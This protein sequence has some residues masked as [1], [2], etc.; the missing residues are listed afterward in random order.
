MF[1]FILLTDDQD[2]I[3]RIEQKMRVHLALQIF[4]LRPHPFQLQI[5]LLDLQLIDIIDQ[6]ADFAGHQIEAADQTADLI[7]PFIH[8]N[9]LELFV[10]DKLHMFVEQPY[11]QIVGAN[12]N[13]HKQGGNDDR[14]QDQNQRVPECAV[15]LMVDL[16]PFRSSDQPPARSVSCTAERP[17]NLLGR[18]AK[19]IVHIQQGTRIQRGEGTVRGQHDPV[20]L[21]QQLEIQIVT[22]LLEQLLHIVQPQ[23][24]PQIFRV[25][26]AREVIQFAD[27]ADQHLLLRRIQRV[28]SLIRSQQHFVCAA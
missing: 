25:G 11:P 20:L 8:I 18:L 1:I 24:D 21:I 2:R 17:D 27:Q 19:Q 10:F 26:L 14:Q 22:L 3:Q 6:I 5:L 12:N 4:Q 23:I 13:N 7:L 28:G 9:A 16:T 15:H